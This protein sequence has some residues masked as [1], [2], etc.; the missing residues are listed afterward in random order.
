MLGAADLGD[1]LTFM[2]WKHLGIMAI[3]I[4]I[5]PQIQIQ[6]HLHILWLLLLQVNILVASLILLSLS[7]ITTKTKIQILRVS[8]SITARL[9]FFL[10]N[11]P[12]NLEE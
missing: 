3:K 6:C 4:P 10:C 7:Q 12:K 8:T 2:I 1:Q 5:L 9:H 11:T